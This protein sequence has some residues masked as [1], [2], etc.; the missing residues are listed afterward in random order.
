M[1]LDADS[2]ILMKALKKVDSELVE[3]DYEKLIPAIRVALAERVAESIDDT[4]RE[5][6]ERLA[7]RTREILD[8]V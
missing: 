3:T 6:M 2:D 7:Q 1:S 8:S 4:P 5:L